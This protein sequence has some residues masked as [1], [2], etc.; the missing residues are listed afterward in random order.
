MEVVKLTLWLPDQQALSNVLDKAHASLNLANPSRESDGT[1]RV[2]LYASPVEAKKIMALNYRHEADV[3]FGKVLAERQKEVSKIDLFEGGK[4]KPT[5]IGERTT[6]MNVTEVESALIGLSAAYPSICELIPLPNATFEGRTSHA[7]R[8]GT[9]PANTVNAYYLTG[10]VHAREWGSCEIL[11]NLATAL[12]EAYSGG[13]G[14]GYGGKYFSAAEVKALME[15]INIIIFPCVNPDGRNYSQL[16][17]PMWRK[18][19]N[20]RDSDGAAEKIGVDVNRNQDFLWDFNTAF[21]PGAINEVLASANPDRETYHGSSPNSEPETRNIN[22]IHDEYKTIRWYVD[23]H[24]M[25]EDILY[26]WGGDEIQVTDPTKNF[27]NPTFNHRRGLIADE[28]EEYMPDAD[29][30]TAL[31]LSQ[32]FNRSLAEVRGKYYVAKP[33]FSLYAT[34]GTNEDYAY[35]RHFKHPELSKTLC[36]TVEWGKKHKDFS[37][38]WAEM[39]E[40]IKDVSAGLMALGLKALGFD[41]FVVTNRDSFSK[42]SVNA[43]KDYDSAFYVIYEGFAPSS[44]GLPTAAPTIK[45]LSS[46]GGSE[47]HSISAEKTNVDLENPGAPT[48]PQRI[49]ITYR[50]HFEDTSAFTSENRDIYVEVT[51]GGITNIA[52]MHLMDQP[53]PYM[54]D[55]SVTCMSPDVRVFQ[56]RPNEKAHSSSGVKLENPNTVPD[57]PYKYIQALIAELRASGNADAPSFENLTSNELELSRTVGGVRVFNFALAKVRYR[58][59]TQDAIDVR[60]FFRMFN[61]TV[62]DLSYTN[63]DESDMKNYRRTVAGT[64]PLLGTNSFFSGKHVQIVSIPY[65]AEKRVNTVTQSMTSQLDNINKQTLHHAGGVEA[66]TYFGCWLDF[67]QDDPQFPQEV[68][69][70]SGS[71]GPFTGRVPITQFVRGI[72]QCLV[73]EIRFQ[74]GVTDPISNGATPASSHR[75]AQRNL[76]IVESG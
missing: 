62:S 54:L 27:Q 14:V 43:T 75:L 30:S 53:C 5:G 70:G 2:T 9:A 52:P 50:V 47:I 24:S 15:Q 19:R 71:D 68:G 55:G 32:T 76:A 33:G 10:G 11:V 69:S 40:I 16:S 13:T 12:C 66:H 28:Y 72:H 64:I 56:L 22:Y 18:N 73:A 67:N 37:F 57:A 59:N 51:F 61:T 7:V 26:A 23:V 46:I 21:A 17:D 49:S 4:V 36:F 8:L 31:S 35:S 38:P 25:G 65:F 39:Q 1:L 74:P 3:N 63:D 42:D 20:P 48:T 60:V 58:A 34:S 29:L 41:S 45:F 44:L 6:Y